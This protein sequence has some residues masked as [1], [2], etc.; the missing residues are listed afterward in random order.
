MIQSREDLVNKF[1]PVEY[2]KRTNEMLDLGKDIIFMPG[3]LSD[4][5]HYGNYRI[6]IAAALPNGYKA[7]VRI[8]GIIPYVDV[9]VETEQTAEFLKTLETMF[10]AADI[11]FISIKTMKGKTYK[12]FTIGEQTFCRIEFKSTFNRYKAIEQLKSQG[13]STASDATGSYYLI[14]AK[15]FDLKISSWLRGSKAVVRQH[16]AE[17]ANS[18]QFSFEID[19]HIN[20]LHNYIPPA[21][22]KMYASDRTLVLAWDIETYRMDGSR[23]MPLVNCDKSDVFMVCFS[24]HWKDSKEQLYGI[25][26]VDQETEPDP[27]WTTIVC[28]NTETMLKQ[29]NM[30]LA[31]LNPDF[32][33][34]FN[35]FRYDWPFIY[36]KYQKHGLLNLYEPWIG[37]TNNSKKE[38]NITRKSTIKLGAGNHDDAQYV[39]LFGIVPIDVR[40]CYVKLFPKNETTNRNSLKYFL[41][42]SGLDSKADLPYQVMHRYHAEARILSTPQTAAN[43]REIANYC[44]IDA[45]RC[46]ELLLKRMVISETRDLCYLANDCIMN[47]FM[48][49]GGS[50]VN[51][52][53]GCRFAKYGYL[54]SEIKPPAAPVGAKKE[55]YLGAYVFPPERGLSP[56]PAVVTMIESGSIGLDEICSL[57]AGSRP[58]VGLDF[59]SLYPSII[60][61]YNLSPEK[62]IDDPEEAR[63]LEAEG[64]QLHKINFMYAG[65]EIV[66][67]SVKHN[68][69]PDMYGV[70]PRI[71]EELKAHRGEIKKILAKQAAIKEAY[72]LWVGAAKSQGKSL[73]EMSELMRKDTPAEI[74][75]IIDWLSDDPHGKYETA[76]FE[77]IKTN[78]KQSAVKV[79]MN[80]FYGEAGNANSCYFKLALA[81]GVTLFGRRT[82]KM[83]AEYV[84][85]RGFRIKYGD[86]DSLYLEAPS[87]EF[88][89]CDAKFL[90]QVTAAENR[91]PLLEL[92]QEW[93]T[94]MVEITKV[95]L[96]ELRAEVNKFL[97][98]DNGSKFLSMNFEEVMY[99]VVFCGKKKYYG[100]PH[101]EV[102]NFFP[103]DLLFAALILF[104]KISP[105]FPERQ[106]TRLCGAVCG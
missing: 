66:A 13:Y 22:D 58:I 63:R 69:N 21:D 84:K 40:I 88:A 64:M 17:F 37:T 25:C 75:H 74:M 73:E 97:I 2:T 106:D 30:V 31:R 82:I 95:K 51:N 3:D 48:K 16:R 54:T 90:A 35:D 72:E 78:A 44:M 38:V 14:V 67:W 102:P 55:K 56:N 103:K 26:L 15:L 101:Y 27:R 70:Y 24:A 65:K 98:S 10:N 36:G 39:S 57:M 86:T 33:T 96:N 11:P 4:E 87:C 68:N 60:C 19:I 41:E 89:E 23:E 94:Q 79:Y 53:L 52:L 93:Y 77:W 46:Q 62:M 18:P 61:T 1:T 5:H 43:M 100:I 8:T 91:R 12:K 28:G 80:T 49:A 20:D 6:M 34:G 99:P 32:L 76:S 50:K 59:A 47:G 85:A 81:G 71:L 42:I 7:L 92:R 9:W 105:I 45:L 29:F 104:A 83:V